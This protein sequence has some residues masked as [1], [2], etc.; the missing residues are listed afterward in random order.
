MAMTN[1]G[2]FDKVDEILRTRGIFPACVNETVEANGGDIELVG[3]GWCVAGELTTEFGNTFLDLYLTR[4]GSDRIHLGTYCS[5]SDRRVVFD[6]MGVLQANFTWEL[7]D[8]VKHN[9]TAFM[10]SC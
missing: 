5:Y 1:K 7:N 2:L 6:A 4:N 10:P 9:L 8:F 3:C